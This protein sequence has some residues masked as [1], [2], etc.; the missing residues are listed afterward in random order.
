MN[1]LIQKLHDS[2]TAE[3]FAH[4]SNEIQSAINA[5]PAEMEKELSAA[6]DVAHVTERQ[7]QEVYARVCDDLERENT[8][9]NKARAW[10]AYWEHVHTRE[11][12]SALYGHMNE[13][14]FQVAYPEHV[15]R[16]RKAETENTPAPW[17]S[18]DTTEPIPF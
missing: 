10:D 5:A 14:G 2:K 8:V 6:H 18:Q 4:A 12:A 3:E 7:A 17:L 1:S 13:A 11:F 15:A 9:E 16:M